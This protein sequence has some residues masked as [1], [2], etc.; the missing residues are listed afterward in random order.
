MNDNDKYII[1]ED[2]HGDIKLTKINISKK[3]DLSKPTDNLNHRV[4]PQVMPTLYTNNNPPSNINTSTKRVCLTKPEDIVTKEKKSAQAEMLLQKV[5]VEK[6]IKRQQKKITISS[7][8]ILVIISLI[9]VIVYVMNNGLEVYD[10]ISLII[11]I[12]I[13]ISK[14]MEDKK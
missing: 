1:K 4:K 11:P 9:P 7:L 13:L 5:I 14:F 12:I 8:I 2:Y 6:H 3:V 10:A